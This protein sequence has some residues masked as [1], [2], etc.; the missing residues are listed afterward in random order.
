MMGMNPKRW[1]L[2][3]L[4][5]APFNFVMGDPIFLASTWSYRLAYV[6]DVPQRAV[7]F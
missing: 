7:R 5:A 6:G 4:A 2:M 1:S 3:F